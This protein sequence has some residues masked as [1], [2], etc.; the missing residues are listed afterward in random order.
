MI[1]CHFLCEKKDGDSQRWSLRWG[2]K[3]FLNQ[4]LQ[5]CDSALQCAPVNDSRSNLLTDVLN[6]EDSVQNCTLLQ[7]F[8]SEGGV[9]L[10][11]TMS[12]ICQTRNCLLSRTKV[13]RTLSISILVIPNFR[14][15]Q[16]KFMFI[17][18]LNFPGKNPPRLP[19][20]Q[21]YK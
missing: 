1:L 6:V 17:N 12:S 18:Y 14:I 21:T 20:W 5:D 16:K 9:L 4:C 13:N 11:I 2:S 8:T 10:T 15:Y 3:L 19:S 7:L